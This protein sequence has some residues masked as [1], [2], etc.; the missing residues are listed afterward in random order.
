MARRATKYVQ[1][2]CHHH[3]GSFKMRESTYLAKKH[4]GKPILCTCCRQLAWARQKIGRLHKSLKL[5]SFQAPCGLIVVPYRAPR[6]DRPSRCADYLD[7]Q[8]RY[9][10]SGYT[11]CLEEAARRM[12]PGWRF[13]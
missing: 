6:R 5:E 10:E 7:C 3:Q 12:W 8:E 4:N 9:G 2:I 11:T 1:A 13:A